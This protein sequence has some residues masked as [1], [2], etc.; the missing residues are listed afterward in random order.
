[1]AEQRAEKAPDKTVEACAA[2]WQW[3]NGCDSRRL[4]G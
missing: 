1:M 2:W 3:P 4:T